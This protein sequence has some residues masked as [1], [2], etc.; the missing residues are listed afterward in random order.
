MR[1][2]EC[3]LHYKCKTMDK[4]YQGTEHCEKRDPLKIEN[5][6]GATNLAIAIVQ[7]ACDDYFF[8]RKAYYMYGDL[9]MRSMQLTFPNGY[10]RTV[11]YFDVIPPMPKLKKT[12][13]A[14]ERQERLN[15]WVINFYS[16]LSRIVRFGQDAE[17]FLLNKDGDLEMLMENL[18]GRYIMEKLDKMAQKAAQTGK[19]RTNETLHEFLNGE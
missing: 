4:D 1:C 9:T 6:I 7:N 16:K 3:E 10:K 19:R 13:N 17:T 18:D 15:R 5:D 12:K 8:Y 14:E 2:D 11:H